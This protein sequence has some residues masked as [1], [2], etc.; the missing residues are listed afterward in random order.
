M[1]STVAPRY[2]F[3]TACFSYGMDRR[4]KRAGVER[5]RLPPAS[6]DSRSRCR[7]GRFLR[8]GAQRSY[9]GARAIAVDLTERMLRLARTR[10]GTHRLRRRR[11][12][13][14]R[15]RL[16]SI[17]S[18][19][20]TGCAT[21][22]DLRAGR[23]RNRTRHAAR[24]TAGQPGFLSA[25]QRS[26]PPPLP[27]LSVRAGHLLGPGAAR[28]AASLHLHP[29][30][31]SKLRLHRRVFR[32]A[33]PRRVRAAWM[34][35]ATSWAASAC[36]GRPRNPEHERTLPRCRLP[37]HRDLSGAAGRDHLVLG[38]AISTARFPKPPSISA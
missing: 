8:T 15:G 37:L 34:R 17:A 16:A 10:G 18:L 9:P 32:P 1:F 38:R 3:I 29:R 6:R 13:S 30:F 22:P 2:D 7:Y 31:A 5:A 24:R 26:V 25:R 36:T 20:A 35:A 27:G 21:F 12:P 19:S 28:P 14:L 23:E 33:A 11:H 4:W